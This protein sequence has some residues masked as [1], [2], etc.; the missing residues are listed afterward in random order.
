MQYLHRLTGA[1]LC[2]RFFVYV[3]AL[4]GGCYGFG[5]LKNTIMNLLEKSLLRKIFVCAVALLPSWVSL[6]M[7]DEPDGY[8]E[9]AYGKSGYALKTA[10]HQIIRDHASLS[11]DA[12]WEA[13]RTTDAR[14]D[15]YVWDMYS[16]CDFRFGSNQCGNYKQ[17]GDCYN[18]EHS[19]PKSWFDDASPMYTDLFHLYPTD[20]Y[21]N[22]RRSNN[23]FGEV[24]EPTYTSQSGCKLGPS[25]TPGYSGTVFEPLDE[26]KGD[27]ART[28]FY[29]ATRYE[30]RIA[31]WGSCPICNGTDDQA[32]DSWVV[33]LLLQWHEQDPVSEKERDRND[34]V[35]VYQENRNPFIDYPELVEKIWGEDNTPFDPEN[36]NPDPDPDPEPSPDTIPDLDSSPY[37]V[38]YRYANSSGLVM[39]ADTLF[40]QLEVDD[41]VSVSMM[42]AGGTPKA[43]AV[44]TLIDEGFSGM[45][46]KDNGAATP[47][48]EATDG[49]VAAFE[50]AVYAVDYAVRMASSSNSGTVVFKEMAASDSISVQVSGR[51]WDEDELTFTLEC[52]GGMPTQ[53][54]LSFS[55][56]KQME[57]LEPVSFAV[58]GAFV[59]RVHAA[60]KQRVF[61]DGVLVT[62]GAAGDSVAPDP[63]PEPNPGYDSSV[64]LN[65]LYPSSVDTLRTD[66]VVGRIRISH[67]PDTLGLNGDYA[68]SPAWLPDSASYLLHAA[69]F[70]GD[71]CLQADSVS[72]VFLGNG[73]TDSIVGPDPDSNPDTM[74]VQGL[75]K[76]VDFRMYPNPTTGEVVLG[77]PSAGRIEVYAVS[78]QRIRELEADSDEVVLRLSRSGIYFVRFV[79]RE[80]IAVKKLVVR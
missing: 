22:G 66:S 51:G 36:P 30:D 32:F 57:T 10:L 24:D 17:E 63:E 65:I 64:V 75:A 68:L 34:A 39:M 13:F 37:F 38:A 46:G 79:S 53:R 62:T 18:R 47:H 7:A 73:L 12:L 77:L 71:S 11:Y 9:Q 74:L 33:D 3:C 58:D 48:I 31:N 29:M 5:S 44:D 27:F 69:L 80:G 4:F 76:A 8:Y 1:I 56:T 55:G 50:G 6:A 78:G 2:V 23:P 45:E 61:L 28:Y 70:C 19:F 40:W 42:L 26:Y 72:F 49:Y 21:V 16:D 60:A 35:Y 15:G 43:G 41:S 59:L 52:Q 67:L 20:G 14:E 25:V 54:E